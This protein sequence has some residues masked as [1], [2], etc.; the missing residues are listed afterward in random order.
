MEVSG[1]HDVGTVFVVSTITDE[2]VAFSAMDICSN[3]DPGSVVVVEPPL[4]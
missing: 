2:G 1:Q 3:L 4:V